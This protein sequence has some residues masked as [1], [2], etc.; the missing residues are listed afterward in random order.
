[1]F[2]FINNKKVFGLEI[3]DFSLKAFWLKKKGNVYEVAGHNRLRMPKGLVV[4]GEIKKASE[5]SLLVQELINSAQPQKIFTPYV[6]SSLP[7]NK[8]FVRIIKVP[9][10]GKKDLEEAVKWEA[11]NHI[12]ISIDDAY[13]DWQVLNNK[14]RNI[15]LLLSSVPKSLI[16]SYI[17]VFNQAK[18][19]VQALEPCAASKGRALVPIEKD[20]KTKKAYL[21][22][23]IGAS[24]T[25]FDVVSNDKI[26]FSSSIFTVS[27]NLFTKTIAETLNIK[28]SEAEQVK[29]RCC[30]PKI[31]KKERVVLDSI[32]SVL[33]KL[34]DEIK[35]VEA[36]FYQNPKNKGI[37]FEVLVCGGGASFFGIVPYLSLK[38]KQKVRLGNP[39]IN[40]K[41]DSPLKLSHEESLIYTEAIGLA[42]RGANLKM[43][44][45]I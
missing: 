4:E 7:E 39:W 32:H 24:K 11:E 1:M 12:P 18:L 3:S 19:K 22:L 5:V 15:E 29:V 20:Q 16:D 34:A 27:G 17:D 6:V 41:L 2:D 37:N 44:Q 26:Y 23:D 13:I 8:T 31:S 33:D 14:G 9:Q 43:Y 25:V 35:K 42:L 30:S 28:E 36:Y 40:I 38:I 21:I 45:N 10:M